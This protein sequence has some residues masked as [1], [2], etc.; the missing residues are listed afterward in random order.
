VVHLLK[1]VFAI[2]WI[3]SAKTNDLLKLNWLPVRVFTWKLAVCI[4]YT[5]RTWNSCT[6][7]V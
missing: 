2:L 4:M 5:W 3:R 7:Q 6:M 1:D